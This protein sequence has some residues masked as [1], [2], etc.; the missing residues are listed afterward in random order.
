LIKKCKF[1]LA[2]N[3]S[4]FCS[5]LVKTLVPALQCR[6]GFIESGSGFSISSEFGSGFG[7][8]FGSGS[9]SGFGFGFRV[10]MTKIK[11]KNKAEKIKFF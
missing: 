2:V 7:S 3:F 11:E 9:G 8:S 5:P 1:F 6:S 4:N 10:L